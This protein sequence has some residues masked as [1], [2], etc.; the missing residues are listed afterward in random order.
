M[1]RRLPSLPIVP[2][3]R[4]TTPGADEPT[5]P[6]EAASGQQAG[7]GG[8]VGNGIPS[9][10]ACRPTTAKHLP[11]LPRRLDGEISYEN[12]GIFLFYNFKSL[13]TYSIKVLPANWLMKGDLV[14]KRIWAH[15]RNTET[16]PFEGGFAGGQYEGQR[17]LV[18]SGEGE[19]EVV[20]SGKQQPVKI[21]AKFLFPQMP[22]S[23][24][25]DV[26][27]ISGDNVGEVYFTRKLRV[28]GFFPL[29][30]RGY[31]SS[32]LCVMEASR[33]ARCDPLSK[34]QA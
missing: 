9:P 17:V 26:V 10:T 34:P 33:L 23:K 2:P 7:T 3:V 15:V 11:Q 29:G 24:G 28:D 30:R 31:T 8:P 22:T 18:L 12:Q 5:W 16:N 6:E 14:T 32:P 21:P 19:G 4:A 25:Q 20:V 13:L 1:G 27:I